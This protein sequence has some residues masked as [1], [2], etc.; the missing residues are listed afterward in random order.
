MP[1]PTDDASSR[2]PMPPP[3]VLV[4]ATLCIDTVEVPGVG[5]V[6]GV[7]GGAAAYFTAAA[8]RYGP[9]RVLAAVG[10]DYPHDLWQ[11]L[12]TLGGDL[13]GVARRPGRTF[14]WR[15]RYQ[16]DLQNRDTLVVDFDPAVEAMPPL[17]PGWEASAYV[18]LGVNA[19]ANQLRL[20]DSLPNTR[21]AVLDTIDLYVNQHRDDL[22]RAIAAADGVVINDWEAARLTGHDD[23]AAAARR[24][25]DL[26]VAFAVVKQGAAGSHLATPNDVWHCP[27]CRVDRLVDPTGAGDSFLGAMLGH[28]AAHHASLHDPAALRHAVAHGTAAAS[29]TIEAFSL[30]R[31]YHLTDAEHADRLATLL[32]DAGLA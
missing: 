20:R 11:K 27:A 17:P 3:G 25:L 29:F 7:L 2:E 10:S 15:G 13:A 30:D 31:W 1:T 18:C 6:D 23:P 9:V 22:L 5:R 8:R 21:L 16:P 19:P 12:Q 28:L 4:N 32:T 26:G 14:R 24:L